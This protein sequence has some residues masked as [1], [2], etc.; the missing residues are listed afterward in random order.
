MIPS[1]S[2]PIL[3]Q[4]GTSI[5]SLKSRLEPRIIFI[6]DSLVIVVVSD[7]KDKFCLKLPSHL[8]HANSTSFLTGSVV[9]LILNTYYDSTTV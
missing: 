3:L 2:I 7:C 1:D 4:V 8:V 9:R 5:N 6:S